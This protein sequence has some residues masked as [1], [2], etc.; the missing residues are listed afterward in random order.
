MSRSKSKALFI[1]LDVNNLSELKGNLKSVVAADEEEAKRHVLKAK[2]FSYVIILRVVKSIDGTYVRLPFGQEMGPM[3]SMLDYLERLGF[4]V[5][6]Y[7]F[8]EDSF[9]YRCV[10]TNDYGPKKTDIKIYEIIAPSIESLRACHQ[11]LK[12]HFGDKR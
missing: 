1:Y 10:Y 8:N 9:F 6:A 3:N 12:K 5:G 4:E 7:S 2:K 11:F